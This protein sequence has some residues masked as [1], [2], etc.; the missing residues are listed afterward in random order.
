MKHA[1]TLTVIHLLATLVGCSPEP[2]ATPKSATAAKRLSGNVD[3]QDSAERMVIRVATFNASL[4]R[5]DVGQLT[6][7]LEG[8]NCVQARQVAEI[9]QRVR[10][11]LLLINELD[12]EADG[13]P[14]QLLND[15]YFAIGQNGWD[16]I[17]FP[18]RLSPPV[19]TGIASGQDL[20]SDGSVSGPEDCY[21]FGRYPGQYGFTVFSHYPIDEAAVRTFQ[22]FLWR[23]MPA[24]SVPHDPASDTPYYP[25]AVWNILR[26]SSKNHC[27]VPIQIG[28]KTLHF[29]VSH[30]TPPVFDGAE[31]RNGARNHDEIRFWTD[32]LTND[33]NN[34]IYDDQGDTGGLPEDALFVIAG[35]LNSDPH[36]G[37]SRHS[38]IREL[39]AHPRVQ[40]DVI[41]TSR[42]GVEA[43]EEQGQANQDHHGMPRHD[44]SDFND[45]SAGNLRVDYVIPSQQLSIRDAGIFWPGKAEEGHALIKQSDHRLVWLDVQL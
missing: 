33:G 45:R 5:D 21:G 15:Q 39:L 26:L 19:N 16:A 40:G 36:D 17:E 35:D 23:D 3:A 25:Q 30:P 38:A 32:Y 43:A 37:D 14:A 9:V 44:T 27:D 2:V 29:L 13:K 20:N 10:P 18:F 24:A 6:A 12:Y 41:P 1:G 34:Y 22:T 4:Y 11:D 31:D 28:D 42:G 8:G 7:E